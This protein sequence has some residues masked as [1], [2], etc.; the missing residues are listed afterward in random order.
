M[1]QRH[2][3]IGIVFWL[4]AVALGLFLLRTELE[5]QS[6]SVSAL[7]SDVQ[8]WMTGKKSKLK[9]LGAHEFQIALHDPIFLSLNDGSFKQVGVVTNLNGTDKRDAMFTKI[10]EV[11]IYSDAIASFPDGFQL[12]HHTTPMSLDWVV[13]TMIP[14]ERQ[15]EIAAL[16]S[17]EWRLQRAEVME[18]LRPVI[19]EGLQTA[20]DTVEAE[21]PKVLR[22]HR[23]EFHALGDRYQAEILKAEIIPLVRE[24]ILPIVEEVAVPVATEV[25][26]SLW[27]RVS[28]WSFTWRYVYDKSPLPKKNAVKEEFQRFL[29]EEALPE[30]RSRSDQFIEMTETIVKRAMENPKVKEVLKRNVKRVIEDEEIRQLVWMVVKETVVENETLRSALEAHMKDQETRAAVKLAG[31]RLEPVVREIGDMIFGSRE[32]GITPEFSRILRSQILTKDR[33]WFVMKPAQTEFDGDGTVAIVDAQTP[34]IYPMAFG[35]TDQ[36]PLTPQD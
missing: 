17:D 15:K 4:A 26:K 28:L 18:K 21:L 10:A 25:G 13:K 8:R 33:R 12:E 19:R 9:S 36:S 30:L 29:D 22:S 32:T 16:I 5:A 3:I 23:E 2:L 11:Q 7:T 31:N 14:V 6:S 20:L 24:E 34:M 1:K 27:K 35:G